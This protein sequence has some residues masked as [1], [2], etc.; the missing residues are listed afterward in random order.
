LGGAQAFMTPEEEALVAHYLPLV[1]TELR[2]IGF[3]DDD[4]RYLGSGGALTRERFEVYLVELRSIPSD[5]GANAFFERYGVD[6]AAIK[7]D[8]SNP[9]PQSAPPNDC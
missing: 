5:I 7:R 4:F 8:S 2:R 1:N 3:I 6:F 9:P